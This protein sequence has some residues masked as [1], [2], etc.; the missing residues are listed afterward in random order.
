MP[1]PDDARERAATTRLGELRFDAVVC[2]FGIFFVPERTS[3]SARAL[4]EGGIEQV[5]V[6]AE[7]GTHPTQYWKGVA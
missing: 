6:A 3:V 5:G 1:T 2:V 4:R 7:L